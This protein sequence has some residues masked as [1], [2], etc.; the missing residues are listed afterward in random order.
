MKRILLIATGGT[1]ASKQ[2][3]YG[4]APEINSTELLGCVGEVRRI[5]EVS[6]YQLSNVDST[7]ITWRDWQ[8]MCRC[9][10]ENYDEYDGFVITHGTDTMAYTAA[11]LSYMIQNNKK[12]I[13]IT[14]SQKSIYE[15][16][17]DARNN[18]WGA[19]L[20]AADERACGVHIVFDNKVILGTRAK[21]V[22]SKSYN[23]FDSM[24]YPDVAVIRGGSV[25]SF[26]R[27]EITESYPTFSDELCPRV[28]YLKLTPATDYGIL[29]YVL[30]GYDAVI[31]ES[32]GVG[33]LPESEYIYDMLVKFKE[34][35]KPVIMTTQVALEGSDLQTYRVGSVLKRD[36][37]VI[38]AYDMTSEAVAAKTMWAL[39]RSKSIDEFS[40]L[41]LKPVF[42]DILT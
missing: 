27:E 22:K 3:E 4:L 28:F 19:F 34:R 13:V 18:L 38:E 10:K 7:N 36:Y 6:T 23:A 30:D 39:P 29:E 24:G 26:I 41:F 20:Y 15:K 11:A 32:F 16:D 31:I 2:T 21:K 5:C 1:I 42:A 17:T 40:Q 9:V 8:N 37:G 14:G 12:P 35:G 25:L 33:G